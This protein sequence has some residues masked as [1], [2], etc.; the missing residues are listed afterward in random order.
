MGVR[1]EV[2]ARVGDRAGAEVGS[3]AKFGVSVDVLSSAPLQAVRTKARLNQARL[4]PTID[5]V[6]MAG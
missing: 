5:I 1:V 2:G 3:D 6:R 4:K